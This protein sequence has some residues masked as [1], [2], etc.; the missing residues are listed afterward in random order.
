MDSFFAHF[1][2]PIVLLKAPQAIDTNIF[3][4]RLMIYRSLLYNEDGDE[5]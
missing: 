3:L 1:L 2:H 4:I 5:K